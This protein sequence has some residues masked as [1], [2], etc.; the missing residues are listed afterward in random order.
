MSMYDEQASFGDFEFQLD[1]LLVA[2]LLDPKVFRELTGE[3]YAIIRATVRSELLY[4]DEVSRHLKPRLG[5]LL[6]EVRGV[7]D[8]HFKVPG[9]VSLY[10]GVVRSPEGLAEASQLPPRGDRFPGPGTPM[11]YGSTF[12][13]FDDI[14]I[15]RSLSPQEVATLQPAEL[16]AF[17]SR[18]KGELLFSEEVHAHLRRRIEETLKDL[19]KRKP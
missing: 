10:G 6:E 12:V 3:Q 18:I 5:S 14:L 15:E 16:A 17:A 19:N 4:A 9:G 2:K 11:M 7:P 13:G 8:L 1:D